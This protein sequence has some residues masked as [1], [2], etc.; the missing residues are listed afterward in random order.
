[1]QEVRM[2]AKELPWRL[3]A[4]RK[5]LGLAAIIIL[6]L[7][8]LGGLTV[9]LEFGPCTGGQACVPSAITGTTLT[10]VSGHSTAP[11]T[12]PFS[13]S[14]VPASALAIPN[15]GPNQI[16]GISAAGKG[17]VLALQANGSTWAWGF[18]GFGG[19]G[20][21]PNI[22]PSSS[23]VIPGPQGPFTMIDAQYNPYFLALRP[24]GTVFSWGADST[25]QLGTT[26]PLGYS[27]APSPYA[28]VSASSVSASST[29]GA[30]A[31]QAD[32]TVLFWGQNAMGLLG[33][34]V[35][36]NLIYPPTAVQGL[37]SVAALI[38]GF[39]GTAFAILNDGTVW[40]WG[41]QTNGLAGN[42]QIAPGSIPPYHITQL[43]PFCA[44]AGISLTDCAPDRIVNVTQLATS[45]NH[46]LALR[47]DGVVLSWGGGGGV[48]LGQLGRLAGSPAA[49]LAPGQVTGIPPGATWVAVGNSYSF[50]ITSG[51]AAYAWG[52]NVA[53]NLGDG[54]TT[55]RNLP[56]P[57]KSP[58]GT[59][60]LTGVAR[61][62]AGLGFS[63]Y[64][65]M[66]DGSV[67][68]WGYDGYG[69]LGNGATAVDP[70]PDQVL[71]TASPPTPFT[72]VT[73]VTAGAGIASAMMLKN[74]GTAWGIGDGF[75]NSQL[76]IGSRITTNLPLPL[77][78]CTDRTN[79]M[80]IIG[81]FTTFT[82]AQLG[83]TLSPLAN[84]VE[85]KL[86]FLNGLARTADGNL[87]EWGSS[88]GLP[89]VKQ[90][91]GNQVGVATAFPVTS[92]VEFNF[93][94]SGPFV[95][96]VGN[97]STPIM[98]HKITT[99]GV[100]NFDSILAVDDQGTVFAWGYNLDG[101]LGLGNLVNQAEPTPV[102]D[103]APVCPPGAA[104]LADCVYVIDIEMGRANSI[105][106]KSDG[107]VWGAGDNSQGQ[108]GLGFTSGLNPSFRHIAALDPQCPF[109]GAPLSLCT[110]VVSIGRGQFD[111]IVVKSDGTVWT[112]GTTNTAGMLGNGNPTAAAL[113]P[114]QVLDPS[115]PTGYLT[116]VTKAIISVQSAFA[117]KADGTVW[118]WGSG[119]DG[120]FGTGT[121]LNS[122]VPIKMN[123]TNAVD[124]A[125]TGSATYVVTSDGSVWGTGT[126]TSGDLG[127]GFYSIQLLPTVIID[128]NSSARVA[129]A[130][131]ESSAIA[132][133]TIPVNATVADAN[134]VTFSCSIDSGAALATVSGAGNHQAAP[135]TTP[136]STSLDTTTL[137]DGQHA[138]ACTASDPSP[139]PVTASSSFF[140][141]NTPPTI[142]GQILT[143][144]TGADIFGASW[145]NTGVTVAFTCS[146]PLSNGYASGIATCSPSATISDQGANQA[147]AG[148]AS[149]NAGNSAA[150]TVAGINIDTTAPSVSMT[151]SANTLWPP[152]H[153]LVPVTVTIL[154]T[155][156]LALGNGT[157]TGFTITSSE[158]DENGDTNGGNGFAAPV[159]VM[160]AAMTYSSD[161]RS[162]TSA[163]TIQLRATRNG[164][165]KAGR[166]YT[167]QVI[168][169]DAAGNT[170]TAPAATVT[171]PHN[172]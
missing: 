38:A 156:N 113:L 7:I 5:T 86:N 73:R 44:D 63:S 64:A 108:L 35:I 47:N 88:V 97:T 120:S 12:V 152:N 28:G 135:V 149:D 51:G 98:G 11:P 10:G 154:A 153:N 164:K 72:G 21:D 54:T 75:S 37:S 33:N 93:A 53:G 134:P 137:L 95:I 26:L 16:T 126:N 147:V 4:R 9:M 166:V 111:Q 99:I 171:V 150:A 96:K 121:L 117:L 68:A 168:I 132:R 23:A 83:G 162:G 41:S 45:L 19:L 40:S 61:I 146:D 78:V 122:L 67:L 57:V 110:R 167:I 31:L 129:I 123:V 66:Q 105:V 136:L 124:I 2:R 82:C 90:N 85:L 141:D 102:A 34:G 25:G 116:G 165:N 58:S 39:G 62:Y 170:T 18:N 107:T 145:W 43:D 114:T 118:A 155:D 159:S 27:F 157:I 119:L 139:N 55:N 52:N 8:P 115:D 101:E 76:G 46:T 92:P 125:A 87:W 30:L 6:L 106:L 29:G 60:Q 94:S 158:P 100:S 127:Q 42:G 103:L 140:V 143:P 81:G 36:D 15:L 59:G 17:G 109:A 142:T 112:W 163:T 138:L 3:P 24:D 80:T 160:P 48:S 131:P 161:G 70:N 128:G 79:G 144:A 133:G 49:Y 104:S 65:V 14:F 32:G 22:L 13:G 84:I 20:I 1:M 89:V 151:L 71:Q 91:N 172:Q 50:A 69:D 56:V 77:L 74:D 130:S 169:A 148:A